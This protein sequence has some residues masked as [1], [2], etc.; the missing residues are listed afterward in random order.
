MAAPEVRPAGLLVTGYRTD[1]SSFLCLWVKRP[2]DGGGG[3]LGGRGCCMNGEQ[4]F[5]ILSPAPIPSHI[6]SS[7]SSTSPLLPCC[8]SNWWLEVWRK[9]GGGG[10]PVE[11]YAVLQCWEALNV[12]V[13]AML[14]M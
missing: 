6:L 2:D 7:L 10:L 9:R 11:T 3:F 5:A 14:G 12:A 4:F 13:G 1:S 8:S